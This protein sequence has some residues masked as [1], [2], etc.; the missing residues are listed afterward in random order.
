MK[1]NEHLE[2]IYKSEAQEIGLP[3]EYWQ[4][5]F[6]TEYHKRAIRYVSTDGQNEL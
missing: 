3:Y 2:H 5:A 1:C 6:I 4:D